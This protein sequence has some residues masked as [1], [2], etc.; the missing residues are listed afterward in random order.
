[1]IL[2]Q[3]C[4]WT[5]RG[6][7]F[8]SECVR[9]CDV[10]IGKW[11]VSGRC[12]INVALG[13]VLAKQSPG[14]HWWYYY[15]G[16]LSFMSSHCNSLEDGFPM[17]C[18]DFIQRYGTILIIPVMAA[19]WT[20][21][22]AATLADYD[23]MKSPGHCFKQCISTTNK[24]TLHWISVLVEAFVLC[25]KHFSSDHFGHGLSQWM[26]TLQCNVVFHWLSPCPEW[27]LQ[28]YRSWCADHGLRI[29]GLLGMLLLRVP[30][31]LISLGEILGDNFKTFLWDFLFM[32]RML[33]FYQ[34]IEA[35]KNGCQFA[36]DIFL[37]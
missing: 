33:D 29:A 13:D 2:K 8:R 16:T 22:K 36:D 4:V 5:V 24:N 10:V 6:V 32:F 28:Y 34:H 9:V 1:M 20:Y 27:S 15:L 18:T 23:D 26:T 21:P 30:I 12:I 31:I 14:G 25:G 17:C 35:E 37:K 3:Y 19:R 11:L 7:L